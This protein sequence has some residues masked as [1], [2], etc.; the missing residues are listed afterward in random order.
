M[1]NEIDADGNGFITPEELR[2]A[3]KKLGV[4]LT[5][6]EAK[7]IVKNADTDGDGRVDY[8]GKQHNFLSIAWQTEFL[9]SPPPPPPFIKLYMT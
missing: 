5:C 1:F 2:S 3:F 8:G 6:D 7:A 4:D 9:Y